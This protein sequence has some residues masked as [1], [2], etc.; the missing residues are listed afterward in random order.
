MKSKEAIL[1]EWKKLYTEALIDALHPKGDVLEIGF[2]NGNAANRI[3]H[4]KP[5]THTI[6]ESNPKIV[7]EAKKW[8]A[9]KE[10]VKIIET[11]PS[12]SFDTI[13]FHT[14]NDMAILN[15]L[16]PEDSLKATAEAQKLLGSLEKQMNQVT[17]KFSDKDIEDF[18]HKIGQHNSSELPQFFKTLKKNGNITEKQYNDSVKKYHLNEPQPKQPDPLLLCLETCLKSHLNKKGRFSAFLSNPLSKYSDSQFFESIITNP[19][20]DYK[21]SASPIKTSDKPRDGLIMLVEKN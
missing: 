15:F 10:N 4:H 11:L 5:K 3:Q 20:I 21:E 18:Y 17:M 1:S 14:E 12:K 7:A 19:D 2:G 13:F 9:Q 6:F 16:F 8:A